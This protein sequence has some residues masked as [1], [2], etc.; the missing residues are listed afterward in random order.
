MF[1][2]RGKFNKRGVM[3]IETLIIFIAMI[4][5]AGV[6]AFVLIR[7]SGLLQQ[8][9]LAVSNEAIER[10]STGFE[11]VQIV[12]NTDP[13]TETLTEFEILARLAAGSADVQLNNVGLT[14]VSGLKSFGASLSHLHFKDY[15]ESNI[16][17]I[18]N[19][20]EV[21]LYNLDNTEVDLTNDVV[22]MVWNY[23]GDNEGMV[24]NLSTAGEIYLDL[25]IDLNTDGTY[26]A[27]DL[28]IRGS[29]GEVYGYVDLEGDFEG[30]GNVLNSSL[31]TQ[32]F[33]LIVKNYPDTCS[34]TTLRPEH[35]YCVTPQIGDTDTKFEAGELLVI[36]YKL[37]DDARLQTDEDF[38][39]NL[40]PKT[41]MVATIA[42]R[43]P[44]V[45]TNF[46]TLLWP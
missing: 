35:N 5:V 10:V 42:G 9:S 31:S 34:F 30:V 12:G 29:D 36:R 45:F 19:S 24:F 44:E 18:D 23:S 4:L 6:A 22:K 32:N 46:K 26:E 37:K 13:E 38:E 14:F 11:F 7:T 1:F 33:T 40:I 27:D 17:L 43:T 8:R 16:T 15:T 2:K 41:G 28:V 39:F 21:E 25:G 20:T 3:G